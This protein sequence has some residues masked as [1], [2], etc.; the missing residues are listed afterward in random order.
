MRFNIIFII[1]LLSSCSANITKLENRSPYNSKGFAYIF[2]ESDN[3]KN[4]IKGRLDNSKL[5]IS[6]SELLY[7]SLIK[8]INPKTQDSLIIN[9]TKKLK[10][11]DFYKIVISEKV[12]EKLN[13][14]SEL[15]LIEIFEIK[16]NKS[17]NAP[18][19]QVK[20]SNISKNKV[21]KKK[22][23][24]IDLY[25]LIASFYSEETARFLKQRISKEIPKYDIKKLKIIK[26]SNKQIDLISG[27]YNAINLI[28]NDYIILRDFGFEQLDIGINE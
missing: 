8:L 7:N 1:I 18:V 21:F 17:F 19:T 3:K 15:P 5:E 25:I 13:I 12:A 27:P 20:I 24:K 23:E 10:Y 6:I 9:N 26:K 14:N 2:K 22:K 16:K 28:K 4:F 11:P